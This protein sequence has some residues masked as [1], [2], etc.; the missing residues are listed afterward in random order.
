MSK[1]VLTG[2]ILVLEADLPAVLRELPNHTQ[3]TLAE[4][5]CLSF[6][7]VQHTEDPLRFDVQETFVD[8]PSFERHQQRIVGTVWASVTENVE[9]HY[10]ISA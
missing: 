5:G 8:Q 10:Q 3:L 1:V 4:P 9:R 2:F 6:S 7:V